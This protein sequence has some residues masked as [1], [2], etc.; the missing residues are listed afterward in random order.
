M[1]D[2]RPSTY[3]PL[4]DVRV[5]SYLGCVRVTTPHGFLQGRLLPLIQPPVLCD[6]LNEV[7]QRVMGQGLEDAGR[8]DAQLSDVLD[9]VINTQ[10]PGINSLQSIG[11]DRVREARSWHFGITHLLRR[12]DLSIG[13]GHVVQGHRGRTLQE[14]GMDGC[15]EPAVAGWS[16]QALV[17]I[18]KR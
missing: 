16:F 18:Q 10:G 14:G 4:G 7:D 2:Q 9:W 11:M 5:V 8:E 17:A 12:R 3:L 13:G 6:P 15:V 1:S